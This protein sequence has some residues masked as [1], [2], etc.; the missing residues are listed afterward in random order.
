MTSTAER[1]RSSRS[2][3]LAVLALLA[4]LPSFTAA[5]GRMPAD[6][7]VFL[8]LDPGGLVR[9][10]AFS[11][12]TSQF[13]GWFPHQTITYLWPSGPW[14]WFFET[15]GAPDWI[16]HRLWIGTI[17]FLGG[18]GVLWAARLLGM[19]KAGAFS[20]AAV[21]QLSPFVLP[22]ISRTSLMLLPWTAVGWLVGLTV[23]SARRGGWRFPA[24][25]AI[26]IATVGSP[27]ATA[28][29]MI[30]PAPVLWLAHES[31][32]RRIS[33][34]AAI[35]AALRIGSLAFAV[36]LWWIVMLSQQSRYGADVLA[37]SESLRA[38]STTAL[39]TETLRGLG[40]W[41]FY[42]RDAYGFATTAS[43]PYAE[44]GRVILVGSALL[45]VCVLGLTVTRW[46]H[47][48]YA[49]LLVAVGIVLA[50]G[51]HP[52]DDPSPLMS[53]VAEASRS[54]FALALRSS[55]RALPLSTFGLAL[56]AGALV[57]ALAGTRLRA[58]AFAPFVVVGLAVL[59]LPA[60]YTGGFVDVALERQQ[61]LPRGW[62]E[63]ATAL[64]ATG[65]ESRVLQLPGAEF[66]AYRWGYTVDPPQPGIL[67]KPYIS[68]DLLP[69]G[70]P[71]VM[72]LLY[73]LDDRWQGGTIEPDSIA[74]VARLL[75]ADRIWV[76]GDSE[77]DRF[78]T[79]RPEL[80]S[81]VYASRPRG[82]G[83]PVPYGDVSPNVPTRP[84]VDETSLSQAA[85]GTPLPSVEIVPVEDPTTIARATS[86]V[87][88]LAGSGDGIVDAAAAGLLRG[89]EAVLYAADLTG[90]DEVRKAGL[91]IV[92]DSNRD[93]AHHWRGS[94]D[95][96]GF[97][98]SGGPTSDVLRDDG[99]DT[100]LAVFPTEDP[101]QQTTVT[102]ASGLVVRASGYGSA[103][104]Y[105]PEHRPAMAVDG[106][107]T[108]SWI[109]GDRFYPEGDFLEVSST[110]GA[111]VL[112][113][114]QDPGANRRIT[115]I[116][117]E[118]PDIDAPPVTVALDETSMV[119]PGQR[120][121]V[122]ADTRV[123][124]VITK[125]VDR[126]EGTDTGGTGVGFAEIGLPAQRE[127]T[128][129]P[130]GVLADTAP[131]TPTAVV[132]T[133]LRSNPLDRWRSDPEAILDRTLDLPA[134]I[135]VVPS[136]T[137][138]LDRRADD[139]VLA[140]LAGFD[141]V[142][143]ATARL[144]G[145]PASAGRFATDGDLT[146]AWTSPFVH[147]V[148]STL[149]IPTD[150]GV[151]I[152]RIVLRQRV[153]AVHSTISGVQLTVGDRTVDLAVPAPD[154]TGASTLDLG[155]LGID[156][157]TGSTMQL[158]ISTIEPR[159]T[160]DRRYSEVTTLPVSLVEVEATAVLPPTRTDAT[161]DATAGADC[162]D[163]LVTLDG[164]GLPLEVDAASVERLL[165]GEAVTVAS[166]EDGPLSLSPGEHRLTGTAG[167]ATGIQVDRV[168]LQSG[169]APPA[170]PPIA[171]QIDRT[172][173]TRVLTVD[174]CPEGCWLIMGEGLNPGWQATSAGEP[175]PAGRQISG[176][177]N[178]WWIAPTD[179]PT[180]VTVTWTPQRAVTIG[181]A[182]S[183]M[184]VLG[185]IAL[186]VRARPRADSGDETGSTEAP[187]LRRDIL[188][189][190]SQRAAVSSAVVLTIGATLV[191]SPAYGLV[192]AAIAAIIVITRR[193][194]IAG[195]GA[196]ALV[197]ALGLVVLL[198]QLRSRFYAS[199]AWPSHFED[200]HHAGLLVV[201]L[202]AAALWP[203]ERATA[204]AQ[205]SEPAPES[206]ERATPSDEPASTTSPTP[207][208]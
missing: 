112:L 92:T 90:P 40:Y 66:G 85:V 176:G 199:A 187:A 62:T 113:Q 96:V 197:G 105:Q 75:A 77:F 142:T 190:S 108:T 37:Y 157:L 177:F 183:F 34:R 35:A 135:E 156:P 86:D 154:A 31:W 147:V 205:T 131:G 173:T 127:V 21:Y 149:T 76:A 208:T 201:V 148:G 51:V 110:P 178:G 107:P 207:S 99:S 79:P 26:V 10:A 119:P 19:T 53:P 88:V 181:L 164:V 24:L 144:T 146:T 165:A 158:T 184:A 74:P 163:D 65:S 130:T 139:R 170:S 7:K 109:V 13:G 169:T 72:D 80:V 101:A 151:S 141:T 206:D 83:E 1:L 161:T 81:E 196:V 93:R 6:T 118:T 64:D 168:V 111:L 136:V 185:C 150:P 52:I 27:N 3:P 102:L 5:P 166:C 175:L 32:S 162:R 60:L 15:I 97:S 98:E 200:L 129:V 69:L 22:Y 114:P 48:G 189:R 89:D 193:P 121:E 204:P 73:A 132:L 17:L 123:R 192:G 152:D 128:R 159:T 57:T 138:R 174:P 134:S 203:H 14:Y 137:L 29:A 126:P 103:F 180:E 186:A 195:L 2:L 12:D 179:A 198:R 133:R 30:V 8:Y 54:S 145:D 33:L 9:D 41:L 124:L 44:S 191:V 36:S 45:V 94:Q 143:V 61:D 56:G 202:L 11:W 59:N 106:D 91:V 46:A 194:T 188:G 82:L 125:V 43:I 140:D 155:A 78:R 100:R 122:P 20:A 4:Y 63:A 115:E 95:V 117:V 18:A 167:A 38:V 120:V 182:L 171:V 49:I 42:V 58:R 25:M 50:V 87:V 23:L 153:D 104:A 71:G 84:M 116:R 47:R 70:S 172:R 39:S 55:T 16:A 67:D 160:I 68:R 28:L